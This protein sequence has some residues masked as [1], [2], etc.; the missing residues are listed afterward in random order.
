VSGHCLIILALVLWASLVTA[1]STSKTWKTLDE[2]SPEALQRLDLQDNTPRDAELPYLPAEPYPFT[3]PYTAEELG[4]LAFELDSPRPRF[5]H[6]WL[7]T[8][9][10]MTADGY[11]LSTNKNVTSILYLPP[12][13]SALLRLVP[14]Q[15]YMRAVQQFTHPPEAA[16]RQDLW[17]EYRTDQ[18]FTKKQ[19]LYRYTPSA[20]RIR[21]QPPPRRGDRLPNTAFTFDDL[22]GRDPWEF[23]WKVLGTDVLYHT[24]RF[25]NTRP[26]IT[27]SHP[28]GSFYEQDT[29]QLKMMG[30]DYPAYRP[31]GGVDCYVVEAR[32]R[33]DWLPTY[34][35]SKILYWIDQAMFCPLRMEQYDHDGTLAMVGERLERHEYPED[36]RRGYT[37]LI[38]LF[39]RTDL[40]LLTGA[41]HDYH[42]KIEW[43]AEQRHIYFS[44]E[45]LRRE[46]FLSPYKTQA[47]VAEPEQFYLRPSLYPDKF[48][49]QRHIAL[50]PRVAARTA[51][52]EA[53]GRVVFEV[54]P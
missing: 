5:S 3:P 19:D 14:G 42:K 1:Q 17:L 43:D 33:P 7:S 47:H 2:L 52:Q 38:L 9:Q 51:A 48:P 45:F 31:D 25:P 21:R 53:A 34:D 46:W 37:G 26:T 4:Y 6:V 11:I 32:P 16:G 36:G 44:P 13:I 24:V 22:Q 30:A 28:D 10:T 8:V 23:S 12:D 41:V 27:L 29:T 39:W 18:T 49:T 20:R 15:A 35:C 40:D 50:S 54:N